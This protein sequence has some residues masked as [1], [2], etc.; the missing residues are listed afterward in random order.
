MLNKSLKDQVKSADNNFF[1]SKEIYDRL[2]IEDVKTN[3]LVFKIFSKKDI[4]EFNLEKFKNK[5]DSYLIAFEV[6]KQDLSKYLSAKVEK[7]SLL[8]KD[9]VLFS[10]DT[11]D[12][13]LEY[14]I[15]KKDINRY[16]LKIKIQK[17]SL[18]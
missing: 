9:V 2:D 5:K 15:V 6:S 7:I 8:L 13:L 3:T 18:K 17:E 14:G 12:L 1:V 10:L 11:K 4:F 16:M